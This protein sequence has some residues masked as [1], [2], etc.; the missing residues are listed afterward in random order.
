MRIGLVCP[1]SLSA[2]GGVQQQVLG[3]ARALE[4]Q[5]HELSI[6][7]PGEMPR[8]C[9]GISAGRA[10]GFRVNGSIAPMAPQPAAAARAVRAIRRGGFDVLHLH[11]PLAPSYRVGSAAKCSHP[12]VS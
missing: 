8:D 6:V 7:A 4:R 12:G 2:P 1:Y 5:G 3:L 10:F 11:E 9:S